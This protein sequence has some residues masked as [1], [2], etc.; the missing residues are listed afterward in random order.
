MSIESE[1]YSRFNNDEAYIGISIINPTICN[2]IPIKEAQIYKPPSS[3]HTTDNTDFTRLCAYNDDRDSYVI[4]LNIC[5]TDYDTDRT[6][7]WRN[8]D[9]VTSNQGHVLYIC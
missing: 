4:N 7:V 6:N 3:E 1:E 5:A 8:R 2:E 9:L